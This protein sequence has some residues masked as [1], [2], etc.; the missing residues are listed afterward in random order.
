VVVTS[1]ITNLEGYSIEGIK[2]AAEIVFLTNQSFISCE[3]T[4]DASG[5]FSCTHRVKGESN[6]ETYYAVATVQMG[7]HLHGQ[8]SLHLRSLTQGKARKKI[9]KKD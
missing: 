8:Y 5:V 7:L 9:E 4:T 1:H 2:V 3:E 6:P